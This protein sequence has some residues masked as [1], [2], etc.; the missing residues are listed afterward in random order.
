MQCFLFV[1]F[2][3][4][5]RGYLSSLVS[6][7]NE[8]LWKTSE[9]RTSKGGTYP[10]K[11]TKHKKNNFS[12]SKVWWLMQVSNWSSYAIDQSKFAQN[13]FVSIKL[14]IVLQNNFSWSFTQKNLPVQS[15]Q[16]KQMII[17]FE[18]DRGDFFCL[19][20]E[21][22]RSLTPIHCFSLIKFGATAAGSISLW[23]SFHRKSRIVAVQK[24]E[25]CFRN[26]VRAT[27]EFSQPFLNN[28]NLNFL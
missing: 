4:Q 19:V 13:C 26:I 5:F 6:Y 17:S 1:C 28:I 27:S 18:N 7:W 9:K 2:S 10:H 22:N 21:I 16:L 14:K 3:A 15:C 20:K 24:A 25:H 8:P 23:I 12:W 11:H